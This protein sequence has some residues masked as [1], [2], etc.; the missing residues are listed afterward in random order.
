MARTVW[1]TVSICLESQARRARLT[2]VRPVAS[3]ALWDEKWTRPSTIRTSSL[4]EEPALRT[5]LLFL[6]FA[7][8]V[9]LPVVQPT[10]VRRPINQG[11]AY[12]AMADCGPGQ[13]TT[14]AKM[15]PGQPCQRMPDSGRSHGTGASLS[16]SSAFSVGVMALARSFLLWMGL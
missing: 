8:V 7:L 14:H 9:I 11:A 2:N 1:S 16:T 5:K 13:A 15:I 4:K 10:S 3:T 12:L 6:A